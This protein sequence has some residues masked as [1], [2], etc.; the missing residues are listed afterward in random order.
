MEKAIAYIRVSD[1][2]QA[3]DGSSLSTQEKQ[4][5]TYALSQGYIFHKLFREEGESAKTDLRP[6]LQEMLQ[7]CQ[8]NPRQVDVLIVPKIDRLARNAHD[9]ANLK[10][11]LRRF[12]VRLESVGERIEDSPVG[13]F[14]ESIMA[15]VAQF[16]NEVRSERCKGGMVEAASQGRWVWRAPMGFQNVRPN[17]KGTIEP[18]PVHADLIRKAFGMLAEGHQGPERVRRWLEECG[19]KVS[20]PML[21]K[22]FSNPA[23][24]G[25]IRAFGKTFTA[26]PPFVPLVSEETFYRA[27]AAIRRRAI[28]EQWKRDADEFPLRGT[29]K[30][31]CGS[32]MTAQWSKGKTKIYPYYR[33]LQCSHSSIPMATIDADFATELACFNVPPALWTRIYQSV[34][35]QDDE[36][37]A[38]HKSAQN[39]VQERILELIELQKALALKNAKGIIPDDIAQS[40]IEDLSS[41][42]ADISSRIPE[43]DSVSNRAS[44]IEFAA[45]AVCDLRKLWNVVGIQK[46]KDL[47]RYIYPH[48]IQYSREM[49]FQTHDYQLLEQIKSELRDLISTLVDPNALVSNSLCEWYCG[50]SAILAAESR[51]SLDSNYR[52]NPSNV[53]NS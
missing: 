45:D 46:K 7:Y 48:G 2:R 39:S 51:E 14:T 42:I 34:A 13:R 11:Q 40:Q 44:L 49:G 17:G 24:I 3:D 33:C 25:K 32:S 15:S 9:Y 27:Q 12:G 52:M 47:L 30:C 1:Q 43:A 6:K 36:D 21:Y 19:L 20:R 8:G 4:V 26:S 16:D 5:T 23:Y 22:L 28:K 10:L 41:Q 18:H 29:I 38:H 31:E 53:S 35:R 37:R 50:L